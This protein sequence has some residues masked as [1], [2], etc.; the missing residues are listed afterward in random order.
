MR[1][2]VRNCYVRKT[3]V[4]DHCSVMKTDCWLGDGKVM[5]GMNLVIVP[6]ETLT[7]TVY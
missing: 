4:S 7:E 5:K 1:Q 3:T 2:R 6:W